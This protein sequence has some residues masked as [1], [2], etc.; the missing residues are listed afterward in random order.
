MNLTREEET[1]EWG[2]VAARVVGYKG[3]HHPSEPPGTLY[4]SS[5]R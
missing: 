4:A 2:E 3:H 1:L 5:G